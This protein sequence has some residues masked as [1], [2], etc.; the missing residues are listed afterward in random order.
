MKYQSFS[1][2]LRIYSVFVFNFKFKY[3]IHRPSSE[4]PNVPMPVQ[5][6][7]SCTG[8]FIGVI[9]LCVKR[10]CTLCDYDIVRESS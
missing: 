3:N 7:P 1:I 8:E 6:Q 5:L 9:L 10:L 4:E 2:I